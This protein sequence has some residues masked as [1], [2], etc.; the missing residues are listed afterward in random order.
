MKETKGVEIQIGGQAC[1]AWLSF[2]K[3][4]ALGMKGPTD[5]EALTAAIERALQ[6]FEGTCEFVRSICE[7]T[8]SPEAVAAL[9]DSWDHDDL[10]GFVAALGARQ[11]APLA[12][13]AAPE[14][15]T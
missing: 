5:T 12:Q 2:G 6:T 13:A 3:C 15:Q 7:P 4:R 10:N 11:A 1:R 8:P 9:V 14:P